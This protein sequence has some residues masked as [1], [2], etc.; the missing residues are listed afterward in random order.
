MIKKYLFISKGIEYSTS[1]PKSGCQPNLAYPMSTK[2]GIYISGY[3]E[4]NIKGVRLLQHHQQN[5]G[6]IWKTLE[7]S[8]IL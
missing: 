8:R 7:L 3:K 2:L 1:P 4:T 5:S 6:K